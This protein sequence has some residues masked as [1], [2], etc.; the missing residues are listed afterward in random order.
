MAEYVP[1]L[2]NE[3]TRIVITT[4]NENPSVEE[5]DRVVI[6]AW[7]RCEELRA[8]VRERGGAPTLDEQRE[9][10]ALV[11]TMLRCKAVPEDEQRERLDEAFRR[12]AAGA[13]PVDRSMIER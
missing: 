10:Y 6:P 13:Y 7:K 3:L 4:R 1:E 11:R 9:V 2:L 8:R 12:S 5:Y